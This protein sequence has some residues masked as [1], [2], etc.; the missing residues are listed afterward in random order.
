MSA[1][2]LFNR[3]LPVLLWMSLIFI[4]SSDL[5][6]ARHTSRFL[7][8]FVR[9]LFGPNVS[10]ATLETAHL[11][12]RKGG[13]LTEY[14]ILAALLWRALGGADRFADPPTV[15]RF[16]I[17]L[18]TAAVYAVGDEFHQ[19]FIPTRTASLGDV[20]IDSTGAAICLTLIAALNLY[21]RRRLLHNGAA[22]R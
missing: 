3:W 19:S 20:L 22:P 12:V 11:L 6:A 21:R 14:A 10:L 8:P 4:G 7:E 15:A 1:R 18:A 2:R 9:W 5:L 16:F 17:A 13:H